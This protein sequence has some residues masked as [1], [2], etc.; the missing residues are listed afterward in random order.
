MNVA[1]VEHVGS[2]IK[3]G[4]VRSKSF[5]FAGESLTDQAQDLLTRA[6]QTKKETSYLAKEKY[7]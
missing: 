3:E 2:G 1:G 6:I 7:L 4:R 5:L